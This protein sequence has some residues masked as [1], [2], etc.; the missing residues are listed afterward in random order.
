M[1][2]TKP[3]RWRWIAIGLAVAVAIILTWTL[4]GPRDRLTREALAAARQKWQQHGPASYV[5]VADVDSSLK[6]VH[7]IRVHDGEVVAM[8]IEGAKA[9]V[10]RHVWKQWS[11]EG[12]FSFIS[13]ELAN[14]ADPQRAYH[15]DNPSHVV[16]RATFDPELGYPRHFTRY[17]VGRSQSI[18]WTVRSFKSRVGSPQSAVQSPES[19]DVSRETEAGKPESG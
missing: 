13:D 10:P 4:R 11:V 2:E 6:V 8:T 1:A 14:A 12:L 18:E 3:R 16:L 17:V 15:V 9:E 19:G 7:S 5:M